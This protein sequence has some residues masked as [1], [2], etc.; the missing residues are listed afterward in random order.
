MGNRRSSSGSTIGEEEVLFS[1]DDEN[2]GRT[3]KKSRNSTRG[4]SYKRRSI[5]KTQ[6]RH[7]TTQKHK[8]NKHKR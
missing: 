7:K 6:R 8:K 2:K 5:K 3:N 4:G 1:M